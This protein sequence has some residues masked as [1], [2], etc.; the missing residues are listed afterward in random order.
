MY[1]VEALD[2]AGNGRSYPDLESDIPYR[3]VSIERTA[4]Q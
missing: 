3:I 4:V 2:R 1:F